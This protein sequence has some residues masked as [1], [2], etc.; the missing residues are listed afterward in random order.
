M[1]CSAVNESFV[2]S[3]AMGEWEFIYNVLV[4]CLP[5]IVKSLKSVHLVL[6]IKLCFTNSVIALNLCVGF[7]LK[8]KSSVC[9]VVFLFQLQFLVIFYFLFSRNGNS[10]KAVVST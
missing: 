4:E 2:V 6:P 5:G 1:L 3:S 10:W 7:T 8:E 9:M